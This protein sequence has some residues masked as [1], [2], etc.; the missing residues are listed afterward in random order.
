MKDRLAHVLQT[1]E[2]MRRSS[3][4]ATEEAMRR[5]SHVGAPCEDDATSVPPCSLVSVTPPDVAK[6]MQLI[7]KQ[8]ARLERL[9][10]QAS[11]K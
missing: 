1:G 4:A 3:L 8:H 6:R 10:R 7:E 11:R 9:R 5:L 2:A